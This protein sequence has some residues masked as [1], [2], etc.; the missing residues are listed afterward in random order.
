MMSRHISASLLFLFC[1]TTASRA[2]TFDFVTVGNVGNAPE[3][4]TGFGAVDYKYSISA[5]E[6]TTAQY[7]E[8]LNA[9]DPTG[10]NSLGLFNP[11]EGLV[12]AGIDDT[13]TSDGARYLA[14]TGRENN[15]VT[16]VSWYDAVRFT[17]WL[18]NGQGDGDTE[19]GALHASGKHRG[20]GKWF[21]R[22]SESGC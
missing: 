3:P 20:S 4:E 1:F 7:V 16:M 15:P 14:Q 12:S 11:F 10:A 22:H 5:T 18:H 21:K 2:V 8:F 6:V 17:N 13:G 19:T 9:V